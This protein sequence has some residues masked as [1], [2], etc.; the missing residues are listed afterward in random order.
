MIEIIEK[1]KCC[2]CGACVQK[3]PQQ[4]ISLIE[5]NEGFL[6]PLV[7]TEKCI[8]CNLCMKVCPVIGHKPKRK[9]I[10]CHAAQNKDKNELSQ[11]SSGGIFII[12]AQYVINQGGFVVG[13]VFDNDWNVKQIISNHCEDI[14]KMMGS[15][16]VQSRTE[17]T[18]KETEDYLKRGKLVLY[19]GTPCQIA[20]LKLFLHREYSNLITID[21]ICHGVPSPLVWKRYL[22]ENKVCS[23]QITNIEF[24]NKQERGWKKYSVVIYKKSKIG[25]KETIIKSEK[26]HNNLYM[27]AFLSDLILRP[28]CYDCPAKELKSGSDLT[29]ADFWNI[30]KVLP[31]WKDDDKGIS[32]LLINSDKGN[33]IVQLLQQ[34]MKIENVDYKS[35]INYNSAIIKSARPH[36][37]RNLFFADFNKRHSKVNNLI[38]KYCYNNKE[39]IKVI[40]RM[41]LQKLGLYK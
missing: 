40:T 18:F 4:C 8:Q 41:L 35:I 15:K 33:S 21:F 10:I 17:T 28:S 1:K 7:N 3:C 11:S 5:D 26:H 6:Y 2:G 12:I 16:Y 37:N 24:R 38:L 13:A 9:P 29:I 23:S 25:T 39:R 27:K 19:T 31:E 30:N 22:Q 36:T 14:K 34:K 20:G 32:I